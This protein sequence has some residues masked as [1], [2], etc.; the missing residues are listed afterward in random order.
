MQC[1]HAYGLIALKQKK[2]VVP[3]RRGRPPSDAQ[4]AVSESHLLNEA[5]FAFARYG[6]EGMTLRALAKQLGVSH[7][8]INVR[9]GTKADLWRCAVDAQTAIAAPPVYAAFDAPGLTAEAQ[10][11]QL[12]HGFCRWAHD[13]PEFVSMTYVEGRHASWRL[14]YLVESYILPFKKRFDDLLKAVATERPV[15]PLTTPALMSILVAGVGFYF[16][17]GPT[18]AGLG[19]SHEIAPGNVDRQI[20]ALAEFI[21]A[22]LLP[23]R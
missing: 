14:D 9:F 21:L 23:P 13:N 7:N 17:A 20:G 5:F 16:A 12:M 4:H 1:Q 8:L 15:T 18:L 3:R 11:R 10:L 2:I 6:Y 22:A 19:A